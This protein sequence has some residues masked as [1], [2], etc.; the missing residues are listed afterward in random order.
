MSSSRRKFLSTSIGAG[1]AG[2][3]LAAPAIVKA[4]SAQTFNWKMTS[5]YPK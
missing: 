5:A 1:V 2:A 4:Q 3:A